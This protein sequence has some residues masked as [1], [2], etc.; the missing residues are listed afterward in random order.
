MHGHAL[1]TTRVG[2]RLFQKTGFAR[3]KPEGDW[4]PK[5]RKF[6][7]GRTQNNVIDTSQRS[8]EDFKTILSLL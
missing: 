4:I 8:V 1:G 3:T 2:R 5:R 6:K 7:A